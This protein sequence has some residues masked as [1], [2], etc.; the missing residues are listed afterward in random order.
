MTEQQGCDSSSLTGY[1]SSLTLFLKTAD[2][3]TAVVEISLGI[4]L[5]I[6]DVSLIAFAAIWMATNSP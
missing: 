5:E 4:S 6:S 2:G 3:K 1:E